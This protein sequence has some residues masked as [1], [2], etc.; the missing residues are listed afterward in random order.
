MV[1][2]GS[3]LS[4]ACIT[5]FNFHISKTGLGIL[6]TFLFKGCLNLLDRRQDTMKFVIVYPEGRS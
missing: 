5:V 3:P 1:T 2:H 6:R 4:I